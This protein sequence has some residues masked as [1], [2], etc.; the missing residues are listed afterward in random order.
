MNEDQCLTL[1]AEPS[2]SLHL[3]PVGLAITFLQL[4]QFIAVCA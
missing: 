4:L 1:K 3:P 2:L